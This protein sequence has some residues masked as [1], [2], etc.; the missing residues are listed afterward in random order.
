MHPAD[1]T[2][3]A[4][5]KAPSCIVQFINEAPE[6]TNTLSPITSFYPFSA[7]ITVKSEIIEF[8]PT[9]ILAFE[10]SAMIVELKQTDELPYI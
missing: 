1:I 4:P 2:E 3:F 5:I 7:L 10:F 6:E 9:I 8:L